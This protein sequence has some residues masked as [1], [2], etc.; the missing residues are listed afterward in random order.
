MKSHKGAWIAAAAALLL[1]IVA[2]TIAALCS[3][4]ADPAGPSTGNP[5]V[6]SSLSGE[7]READWGKTILVDGTVYRLNSSLR[8][9]LF[10]G[11]DDGE[12]VASGIAPGEGRRAD[13]I[14]LL[15]LDDAAKET[16]L[17]SISRDT[18]VDVDAYN[19][20]GDY[21]YSAPSHI[22]MQ[23]YFGD[24][25]SRSCY[26]MKR[27][28]S[29]LLYGIQIDGCFSLTAEGIVTV[30]DQLGGISVTMPE[31]YTDVDPRYEAGAQ[32]TLD[33][34]EAD[35]LFRYRD[36]RVVGSNEARA[37][38][39]IRL[40]TS[41]FQELQ[42]ATSLSRLESLL[43]AAGEDVCSDL[44][45]E[46]LKKL[47]TYRMNPASRTLPGTVVSGDDGHDE[48][49]VDEAALRKLL[50]ELFYQPVEDE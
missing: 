15:L 3:G 9:I 37:E 27:T 20:N 12:S 45:A 50:I 36:T 32:L 11:V 24:S 48:F 41:L 8:T 18:I 34:R 19:Q 25:P 6:D 21:A 16:T 10:L 14:V 35:R 29:R 4:T 22:N 30:V 38:R 46:T 28:V 42:S 43:E 49:H 40:M 5:S 44:D 31:D 2:G 13:T 23:Y 17:L 33:G 39:Q 7:E 1:A 47:L 26:L